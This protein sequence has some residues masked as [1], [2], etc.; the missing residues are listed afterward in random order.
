MEILLLTARITA[1]T[2]RINK[3][4]VEIIICKTIQVPTL[5]LKKLK[6]ERWII[7]PQQVEDTSSHLSNSSSI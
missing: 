3:I 5:S 7:P 4:M 6:S 1:I 2:N